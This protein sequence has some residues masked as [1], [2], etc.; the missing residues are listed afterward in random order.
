MKANNQ[1]R[2]P[3]LHHLVRAK[4]DSVLTEPLPVEW[5]RKLKQIHERER[6]TQPTILWSSQEE[7]KHG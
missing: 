7:H 3:A 2:Y 4:F 1:G 6:S 5:M